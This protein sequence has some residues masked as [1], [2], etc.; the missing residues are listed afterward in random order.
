MCRL[1]QATVRHAKTE[2]GMAVV[3]RDNPVIKRIMQLCCV[4]P[5]APPHMMRAALRAI[6][7]EARL[8]IYYDDLVPYFD[9]LW[10]TWLSGPRYEAL[11]VCGSVHRTNNACESFNHM[12]ATELGQHHVNIF[13]FI[14]MFFVFDD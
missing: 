1:L 13:R 5:L 2:L 3:M 10:Y 6:A 11:S 8:T 9:Y 12:M 4:I 14:G 7:A